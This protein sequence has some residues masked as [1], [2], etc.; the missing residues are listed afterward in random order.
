[1][2]GMASKGKAVHVPHSIR[3]RSQSLSARWLE[4]IKKHTYLVTRVRAGLEH[5]MT[6]TVHFSLKESTCIEPCA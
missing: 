4:H 3:S 1:M 6:C 2:H 5:W